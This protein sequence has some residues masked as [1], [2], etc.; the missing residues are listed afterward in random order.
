MFISLYAWLLWFLCACS[1]CFFFVGVC[2]CVSS[3]VS[4]EAPAVGPS[5]GLTRSLFFVISAAF[6]RFVKTPGRP[7]PHAPKIETRPRGVASA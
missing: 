5:L 7:S 6:V 1:P 4:L 3:Y 2:V